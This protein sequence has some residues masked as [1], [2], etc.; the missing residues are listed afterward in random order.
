MRKSPEGKLH[1]R[2]GAGV[3]ERD[4]FEIRCTCK[5]TQGSNPCLSAITSPPVILG[6]LDQRLKTP[7]VGPRRQM[8]C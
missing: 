7:E 8:N 4:G 6:R 5:G 1:V 2:R 3:V